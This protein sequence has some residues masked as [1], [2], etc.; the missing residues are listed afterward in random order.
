MAKNKRNRQYIVVGLGRF[1]SAIAETLCEAGEE[2]MG[3]DMNM[4]LVEDMKD[5]VTHTVQMD[6]M[7]RDALE[8]LGVSDFDVAFV[9]M[10]SDIRASGTITLMLKELGVKHVIAKAH[11]DFHGRMLEKLG[12]DEVLFPERD[13]GR[14]IAHNLVSGN[15]IDYLELSPDYSMAEVRPMREWVGKPLKELA[16]RS[17]AGLNIIVIKN[18]EDV[19]PMPQPETVIREGDVLLVVAREETLAKMDRWH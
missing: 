5:R 13:M 7:D 10:G 17:R 15:I 4:D 16:L 12:A 11:D 8:A 18:G 6:A 3:V 9:T 14:R 1:G 19:N 2:V